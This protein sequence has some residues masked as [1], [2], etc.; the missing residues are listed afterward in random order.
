MPT[1]FA[2]NSHM[3]PIILAK[4]L[5]LQQM[6]DHPWGKFIAPEWVKNNGGKEVTM[7]NLPHP[8]NAK[9]TGAPIDMFEDFATTG[10]TD[11]QIPVR[12]FL[13]GRPVHGDKAV[14][15]TGESTSV[16]FRSV[17]INYTRKAWK[18][19]TGMS[20]QIA[21]NYDKLLVNDAEPYLRQWLNNYLPPN[22]VLTYLAGY[23]H[24]LLMPSA[25]LGGRGHAIV[26]HPN[27]YTPATGQVGFTAGAYNVGATPGTANYEI[28]VET[29]LN[30][31]TSPATHGMSVAW[32]RYMKYEAAWKKIVPM[33]LQNGYSF[34]AMFLNT[35][36][37]VQLKADPEYSATY[38]KI[39]EPLKSHPLVTG[40]VCMIDG[41]VVYADMDMFAAHTNAE[42]AGVVTANEVW[43]GPLPS[44]ADA[45]AGIKVG[46]IVQARDYGNIK[47]GLLIGQSSASIGVSV[48]QTREGKPG[49]RFTFTNEIHD[50][51]FSI[52]IALN[53]VMSAVRNDNYDDDGMVGTAGLFYENTSSLAFATFSPTNIWIAP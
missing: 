42:S 22:F 33:V 16:S 3:N 10:R 4:R 9:F 52:E 5:F 14:E 12:N 21:L 49:Q 38:E 27:F 18:P 6:R 30:S 11:M 53:F 26:S 40:A 35:E 2:L 25:A 15:G 28:A 24:D 29:A 39:P 46:S 44:V 41:V 23:S 45:A 34:Y 17:L 19:A 8:T 47:C 51:G 31:L 13:T 20:R 36:Q 7:D 43:Y 1:S 37:L 48:P 32:L 50:H